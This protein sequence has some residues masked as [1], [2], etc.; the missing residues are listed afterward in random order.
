MLQQAISQSG[1]FASCV[2]KK[3][4]SITRK[5]NEQHTGIGGTRT[6]STI[7]TYDARS[8]YRSQQD[9]VLYT[10]MHVAYRIARNTPLG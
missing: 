1:H 2:A 8:E 6:T 3:G 10:C 9:A 4:S 7:E 5:P